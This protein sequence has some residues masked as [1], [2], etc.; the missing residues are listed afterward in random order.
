MHWTAIMG[1]VIGYGIIVGSL[2]RKAGSRST[3]VKVLQ[4]PA[5]VIVYAPGVLGVLSVV[6]LLWI[7][8]GFSFDRARTETDDSGGKVCGH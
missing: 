6:A 7:A 1:I 5:D 4:W 2:C 3:W 8:N